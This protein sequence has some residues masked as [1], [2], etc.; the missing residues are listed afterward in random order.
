MKI[1]I[2]FF[3]NKN[4]IRHL[5]WFEVFAADPSAGVFRKIMSHYTSMSW[6]QTMCQAQQM[7]RESKEFDEKEKKTDWDVEAYV[8]RQ[9]L[10]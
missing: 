9:S 10:V 6:Q 1:L 5:R 7:G 3:G 4:L 8:A 2:R